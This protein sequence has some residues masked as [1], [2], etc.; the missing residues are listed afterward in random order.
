MDLDLNYFSCKTM[1][2]IIKE[3]GLVR[4]KVRKINRARNI[5]RTIK[6]R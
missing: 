5:D 3:A 1:A 6:I 4:K 2:K